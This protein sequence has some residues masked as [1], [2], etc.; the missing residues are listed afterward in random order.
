M[1][2]YFHQVCITR[3]TRLKRTARLLIMARRCNR[4]VACLHQT[5]CCTRRSDTTRQT[6]STAS[7][8][9][10]RA[11]SCSCSSS[12]KSTSAERGRRW[13]VFVCGGHTVTFPES[14]IRNLNQL[15]A[16]T[17]QDDNCLSP[18]LAKSII[19]ETV[20]LRTIEKFNTPRYSTFNFF[21]L[22][23]FNQSFFE[24]STSTQKS[25]LE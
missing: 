1:S 15:D 9:T 3:R 7:R 18:S 12:A 14:T 20:Q 2:P 23:L 4:S 10:A 19:K 22:L 6:S 11:T 8:S 5:W 13:V 17:I 25:A 21:F 16:W 24:I